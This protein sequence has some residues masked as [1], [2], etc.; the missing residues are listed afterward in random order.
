MEKLIDWWRKLIDWWRNGWMRQAFLNCPITRWEKRVRESAARLRSDWGK[1]F[2]RS[3]WKSI[4]S[5]V[6]VPHQCIHI[7]MIKWWWCSW[8]YWCSM[9]EF[10]NVCSIVW[11]WQDCVFAVGDHDYV[12][13]LCFP[14]YLC[15]GHMPD[16]QLTSGPCQVRQTDWQTD[17]QTD[18]QLIYTCWPVCNTHTR[19]SV[20]MQT[21]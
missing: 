20:V 12:E 8:S 9:T 19:T 16:V 4:Q 14:C 5:F 3:A 1:L 15:P 21:H 6:G 18:R 10:M 11:S 17:R 7:C 2:S 13:D